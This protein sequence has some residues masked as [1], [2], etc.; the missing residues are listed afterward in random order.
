MMGTLLQSAS[1]WLLALTLLVSIFIGS[2][3]HWLVGLII[4]IVIMVKGSLFAIIFDGTFTALK[5]HHD[6]NDDRAR[7][8]A[9]SELVIQRIKEREAEWN[10]RAIDR[11]MN[12]K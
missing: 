4:F 7:K 2:Y 3:T 8:V 5:Y 9:E 11:I 1:F 10:S 6:R 12:N